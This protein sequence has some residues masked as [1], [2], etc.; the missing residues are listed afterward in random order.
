[1]A[2]AQMSGCWGC[3]QKPGQNQLNSTN[4]KRLRTVASNARPYNGVKEKEEVACKEGHYITAS[5]PVSQSVDYNQWLGQ[6]TRGRNL[7]A[8]LATSQAG[9]QHTHSLH[10]VYWPTHCRI[11]RGQE[12]NISGIWLMKAGA[13]SVKKIKRKHLKFNLRCPN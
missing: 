12:D 6:C 3:C 10:P 4:G 1:M 9:V 13:Y 5:Q 11:R 8:W 2:H 7:P